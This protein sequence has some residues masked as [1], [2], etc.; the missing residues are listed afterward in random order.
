M[1]N[2]NFPSQIPTSMSTG[3]RVVA[4]ILSPFP[5]FR[6]L[7]KLYIIIILFLLFRQVCQSSCAEFTVC[8][9]G[10]S[11]SRPAIFV[12]VRVLYIFFHLASV[13]LN[14]YIYIYLV[15]NYYYYHH[16]HYIYIYS[17]KIHR[18]ILY[19]PKIRAVHNHYGPTILKLGQGLLLLFK[20]P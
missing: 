11:Q 20:R 4:L 2:M 14:I 3:V 15:S 12:R 5:K 6:Y 7:E 17:H 10:Q 1:E 19:F 8:S 13:L 18:G 16:N 9:P